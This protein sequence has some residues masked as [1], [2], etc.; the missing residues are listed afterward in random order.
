MIV[1][2]RFTSL[3]SPDVHWSFLLAITGMAVREEDWDALLN[4]WMTTGE[5][6]EPSQL[7]TDHDALEADVECQ[8]EPELEEPEPN[9]S[10]SEWV[11]N[12]VPEIETESTP[13]RA[14]TDRYSLRRLV[15]PPERLMQV[16]IPAQDELGWKRGVCKEAN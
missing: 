6:K 3:E 5:D 12:K 11:E 1:L 16:V 13:V 9:D 4:G 10:D 14:G 8:S 15:T 7:Q 2:S